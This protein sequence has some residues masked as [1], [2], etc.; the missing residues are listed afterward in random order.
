MAA[1]NWLT[2]AGIGDANV[3]I[4]AK[5]IE[6]AIHASIKNMEVIGHPVIRS[7]LL[8]D[9]G[10]GQLLG[11]LALGISFVDVGQGKMA[12]VAEGTEATPTNFTSSA[13]SVTPARRAWARKVSDFG[14]SIQSALLRGVL[15]PDQYALIVYDGYRVWA[16]SYVDLAV[17][18]ATSA[19]NVIGTTGLALTWA[20][21][22]GGV[23]ELKDRGAANGPCLALLTSKGVQDLADDALSLG[24][25]VQMAQQIQQLIPNAGNGAYL[26]NYFGCCD[27][28][29]NSELNTIAAD[30][31]G[32]LLTDGGI[33]TKHQIVPLPEE[34]FSLV[35]A[36][37][38]TTEM[39]RPGGGITTFETVSHF[40]ASIREQGRLAQILYV[41]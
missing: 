8:R 17:A 11:A 37:L 6:V 15:T 30:T 1:G 24:G 10:L 4:T 26:G 38:F 20:A 41:T 13:I 39:R 28:Y 18:L 35:N 2:D 12:T 34:S 5:T 3:A 14:A 21:L 16:N 32:L 31:A 36:G 40:G 25:A 23:F 9:E 22:S 19:T 33:Q 7:M 29:M 27:L